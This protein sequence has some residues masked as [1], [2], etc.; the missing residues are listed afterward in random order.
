M[1]CNA[2]AMDG[3][4]QLPESATITKSL[5]DGGFS[6]FARESAIGE[7]IGN[8]YKRPLEVYM[9]AETALQRYKNNGPYELT[10][11]QI[12]NK[13][14]AQSPTKSELVHILLQDHPRAIKMLQLNHFIKD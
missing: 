11:D 7:R 12:K 4:Y 13:T 8:Q 2:V 3:K 9:E 1:S 14:Y 6:H 10:W 5:W